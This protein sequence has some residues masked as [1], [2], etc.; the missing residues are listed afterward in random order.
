MHALKATIQLYNT[1]PNL[2]PPSEIPSN[3]TAAFDSSAFHE[4]LLFL[5][6]SQWQSQM[7]WNPNKASTDG[8]HFFEN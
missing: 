6:Y 2:A 4:A 3:R 5:G 7:D 1:N 8:F